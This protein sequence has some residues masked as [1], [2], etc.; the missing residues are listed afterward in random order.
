MGSL[1]SSTCL[2]LF[3]KTEWL[4]LTWFGG[5]GGSF[6]PIFVIW[7]GPL[8][9]LYEILEATLCVSTVEIKWWLSA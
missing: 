2:H 4:T 5:E 7:E 1:M 3:C 8:A 9:L 6:V